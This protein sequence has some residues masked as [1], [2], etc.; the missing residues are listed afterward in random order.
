LVGAEVFIS[1][2]RSASAHHA[3]RLSTELGDVAFLDTDAVDN[4]DVFQRLH[5]ELPERYRAMVSMAVTLGLR[6]GE[7]AALRVGRFDLTEG[8]VHI[9]EALGEAGGHSSPRLP[10]Y[11]PGCAACPYQPASRSSSNTTFATRPSMCPT[12]TR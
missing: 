2:A 7:V 9:R 5:Q 6:F 8:V 4:L 12:P 1:Y 11:A 10:R 3:V